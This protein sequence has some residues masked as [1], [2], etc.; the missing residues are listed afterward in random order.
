MLGTLA[1]IYDDL[2]E[3]QRAI[4][5]YEEAL[6]IV[7]DID[8]S[9]NEGTLLLNMTGIMVDLETGPKPSATAKPQWRSLNGMRVPTPRICAIFW[10]AG[11]RK[12]S[13]RASS[14]WCK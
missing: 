4:E 7:R 13:K 6:K 2:G 1:A 14:P 5:S 8:D 3:P 10:P 11:T 9:L 12:R